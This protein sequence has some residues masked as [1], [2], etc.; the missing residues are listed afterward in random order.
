MLK[1]QQKVDMGLVGFSL[2]ALSPVIG[3]SLGLISLQ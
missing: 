2:P 1:G 3:I